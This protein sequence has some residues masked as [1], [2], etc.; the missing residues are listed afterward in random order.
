MGG[1]E[2]SNGQKF[3]AILILATKSQSHKGKDGMLGREK[4]G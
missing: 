3:P 2:K 1:G 4:K